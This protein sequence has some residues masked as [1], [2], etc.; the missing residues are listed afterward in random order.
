[1]FINTWDQKKRSMYRFGLAII[2]ALMMLVG[3]YQSALRR[4]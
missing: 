3:F 4:C 1:M 2:A